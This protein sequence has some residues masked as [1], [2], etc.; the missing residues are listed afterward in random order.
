MVKKSSKEGKSL[1][2]VKAGTLII[3]VVILGIHS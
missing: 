2:K 1:I 3:E